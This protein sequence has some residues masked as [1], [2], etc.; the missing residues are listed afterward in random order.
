MRQ[1]TPLELTA[2]DLLHGTLA[3]TAETPTSGAWSSWA[4]EVIAGADVPPAEWLCDL[5]LGE[6]DRGLATWLRPIVGPDHENRDGYAHL[7]FGVEYLRFEAGRLSLDDLVGMTALEFIDSESFGSPIA[8]GDEFRPIRDDYQYE[9]AADEQAPSWL[10]GL[11]RFFEPHAERVYK[12]FDR[13]PGLP[14][15]PTLH[16]TGPERSH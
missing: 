8:G 7:L 13:L 2:L 15:N 11:S 3:R 12:A 10:A 4:D 14:H 6:T 1:I 9:R 16:W 5:S